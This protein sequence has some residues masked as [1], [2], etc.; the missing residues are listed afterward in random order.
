MIDIWW[1]LWNNYVHIMFDDKLVARL[2]V[3]ALYMLYF[4]LWIYCGKWS[5]E[6]NVSV[7]YHSRQVVY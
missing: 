1:A 7:P 4:A 6:T 2:C 3:N 5:G